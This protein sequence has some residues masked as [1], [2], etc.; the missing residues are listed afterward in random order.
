MADAGPGVAIVSPLCRV[1]AVFSLDLLQGYWKMLLMGKTGFFPF[2][3][4]FRIV[5]TYKSL[6]SFTRS[7]SHFS[8]NHVRYVAKAVFVKDR[9]N[10][11]GVMTLSPG[12]I[13]KMS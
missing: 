12:S 10:Y 13:Y 2:F 5:H 9:L 6:A 1:L 4:T 8:V 7:S 11:S 3:L